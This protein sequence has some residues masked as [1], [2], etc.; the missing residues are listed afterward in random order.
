MF[1]AVMGP[2]QQATEA[3]NK[4]RYILLLINAIAIAGGLAVL[5]EGAERSG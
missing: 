3:Q 4:L 2:P 1:T 5:R